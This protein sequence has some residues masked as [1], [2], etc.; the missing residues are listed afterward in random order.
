METLLVKQ[1][2]SEDSDLKLCEGQ[3]K[4]HLSKT[5]TQGHLI[6]LYMHTLTQHLS[7]QIQHTHTP[8]RSL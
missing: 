5:N 3:S 2:E 8:R 1:T 4:I 6:R 7:K